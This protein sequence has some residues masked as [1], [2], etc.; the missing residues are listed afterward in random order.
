MPARGNAS[1]GTQSHFALQMVPQQGHSCMQGVLHHLPLLLADGG[2]FAEQRLAKEFC[3]SH[4]QGKQKLLTNC[5]ARKCL[6]NDFSSPSTKKHKVFYF[7][8]A[9]MKRKHR[10]EEEGTQETESRERRGG[11]MNSRQMVLFTKHAESWKLHT[12]RPNG[13]ECRL[14]DFPVGSV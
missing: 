5:N 10:N 12:E 7:L 6:S 13:C 2:F 14:W 4:V 3:S 1:S 11:K 8:E 9:V